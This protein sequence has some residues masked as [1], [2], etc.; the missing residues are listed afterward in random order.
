MPY[1]SAALWAT[2]AYTLIA[3]GT[4]TQPAVTQ[5]GQMRAVMRE[6]R[7]ESRISVADAVAKPH[8]IGVGALE[9]LAGEITIVDGD[10][11]V[12]RVAE[13][14]LRITGPDPV[15]GDQASLLTLAYVAQW[16][17]ITIETTTEGR[18]LESL[19]EQ[20]ALAHGIDTT[21]PFPFVIEGKSAHMDIHVINGYC[22]I[23]TDPAT[24]GA[25]P[26]RWSSPQPI[27]VVIVGFFARDAAGVMT[28]HG[29]AVHAHAVL[30]LED[31]TITGHID[32]LSVTRGMTLRV[33]AVE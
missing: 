16:K 24:V 7:T 4:P 28:H 5:Y 3:A 9:G 1:Y 17:T 31:K 15:D 6:G 27:D 32:Q 18:D 33:P 8:A 21:E 20:T 14:D 25:Q 19:I 11:W 12:S 13:T 23:A 30:S 26:W 10:V 22:P 2:L 29:T